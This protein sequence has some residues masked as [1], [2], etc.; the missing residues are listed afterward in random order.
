[1]GLLACGD[2]FKHKFNYKVVSVG[3]FSIWAIWLNVEQTQTDIVTLKMLCG[4]F[5]RNTKLEKIFKEAA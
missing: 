2:H 1:M 5:F 3:L 4:F